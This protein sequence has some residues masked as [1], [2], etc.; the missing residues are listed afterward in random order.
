M[1]EEG[2]DV[3]L[4]IVLS[5]KINVHIYTQGQVEKQKTMTKQEGKDVFGDSCEQKNKCSYLHP[6]PDEETRNPMDDI[7]IVKAVIKEAPIV[8]SHVETEAAVGNIIEE[9][10]GRSNIKSGHIVEETFL[11]LEMLTNKPWIYWLN[12][13]NQTCHQDWRSPT[14]KL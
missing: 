1:E 13:K 6:S 2:K 3:F 12:C 7:D 4:E 14:V 5:R 11:L 8:V 9:V 10:D